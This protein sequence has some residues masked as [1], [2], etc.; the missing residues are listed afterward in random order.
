MRCDSSRKIVINGV[1]YH[2][3]IRLDT[4]WSYIAEWRTGS[5]HHHPGLS[6]GARSNS[7]AERE[8]SDEIYK[9]HLKKEP[10]LYAEVAGVEKK[11]SDG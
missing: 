2:V 5:G 6:A 9:A 10:W 3:A 7:D 4:H 11:E 8:A 1:R